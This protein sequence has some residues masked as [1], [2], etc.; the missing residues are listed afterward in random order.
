[1][2]WPSATMTYFQNDKLLWF[3]INI[4]TTVQVAA[5]RI[6]GFSDRHWLHPEA[7][8]EK[9]A[10]IATRKRYCQWLKVLAQTFEGFIPGSGKFSLSQNLCWILPIVLIA[11]WFHSRNVTVV[12]SSVVTIWQCTF[13][14][15][16]RRAQ[17]RSM[18]FFKH[19]SI[20][21]SLNILNWSTLLYELRL[22]VE[23]FSIGTFL[24]SFFAI[25]NVGLLSIERFTVD[26]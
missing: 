13:R 5:C 16:N 4:K 24:Y 21:F 10:D 6:S 23:Q 17:S 1:M 14:Q 19:Q 3:A 20:A 15:I 26:W 25:Q 9:M 11:H 12:K 2:A 18:S 7:N 22:K 8:R